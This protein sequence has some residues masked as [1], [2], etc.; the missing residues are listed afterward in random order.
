MDQHSDKDRIEIVVITT[1]SDLDEQFNLHEPLRVVFQKAL[2][3]VGGQGQPDQ[4]QLEFAGQPLTNMDS[5]LGQLKTQ[6][7][8]GD[9]VELEL[10][11]K[12]VVV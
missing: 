6:L 12:P 4:F 7:G 3:L 9:R 5:S 8:W 11:P 10:V 2:V 1:A